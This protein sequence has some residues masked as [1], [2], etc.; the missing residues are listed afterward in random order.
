MSEINA[1]ST[2][3]ATGRRKTATARVRLLPGTG[4]VLINEREGD[5]YFAEERMYNAAIQPLATAGLSEQF[6]VWAR[7]N[8]GGLHGQA[9]AISQGIARAL[10]GHDAELRKPL[11]DA[12]HLKRDPRRRERKKAGQPGARKRFQFSKR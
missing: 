7:T 11:K 1:S 10:L 4:K 12:G 8:G 2:L 6:D 3:V 9:I 5:T